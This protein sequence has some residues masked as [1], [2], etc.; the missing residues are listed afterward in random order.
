MSSS[1]T[2]GGA[3]VHVAH[4][5]QNLTQQTHAVRL[6]MWLFLATEVL[7]FGGLFVSYAAYRFLF[8]ETFLAGSTHL[9]VPMGAINTVVLITSSLSVALAYH[10][11]QHGLNR[12]ACALLLFTIACALT[13]LVIKG[14][15][16]HHHY[17][18]GALPGAR[19]AVADMAH[20]PAAP[21][22]FTLY[23]FST[24]LHALHVIVG[25]VVLSFVLVHTWRGEYSPV[26][27]TPVEM[28][29]LYWHLVDLIWIFLF[30]L[31]YLI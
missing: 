30:P 23:F 3:A 17:E 8:H 15:E 1:D 2:A 19:F 28:G 9:S 7:L 4:H 10:A 26:Y 29:G 12:R 27:H 18:T 16:Y 6:G 25:M 31:L 20:L 22:F 21:L 13:F 11:V 14:F 24:G 5:F